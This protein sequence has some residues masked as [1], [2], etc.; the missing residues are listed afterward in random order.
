MLIFQLIP[1][2][3]MNNIYKIKIGHEQK[4]MF[5]L[6]YAENMNKILII[7]DIWNNILYP[8]RSV[9]DLKERYYTICT[10]LEYVRI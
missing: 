2:L 1:M 10:T 9:E 6:I 5:Y 4:Q 3:N 7:H 8:D